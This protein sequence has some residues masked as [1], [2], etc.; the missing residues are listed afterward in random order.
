[1]LID[2][3]VSL[4]QAVTA[5]AAG[6]QRSRVTRY[7]QIWGW[8]DD[9]KKMERNW[10]EGQQDRIPYRNYIYGQHGFKNCEID[11]RLRQKAPARMALSRVTEAMAVFETQDFYRAEFSQL[12]ASD[13]KEVGTFAI[14]AESGETVSPAEVPE[15]VPI[16]RGKRMEKEPGFKR[17]PVENEA[18]MQYV[19]AKCGL[20]ET[21]KEVS[22][23]QAFSLDKDIIC[24]RS[25]LV[26]LLEYVS[27][28]LTSFLMPKG[29][30]KN[31]VDL[32][33]ISKASDGK[34]LVMEHLLDVNRMKCF[35][36][37]GAW[38]RSEVSNHGTYTPA[39]RRLAYGDCKTKTLMITGLPQIAGSSAGEIDSFYR[40]VEFDMGGIS[41]LVKTPAHAQKDGENVELA[42]K[43]WYY[44]NEVKAMTTYAKMLLGKVD[45]FVLALQRSGKIHQASDLQSVPDTGWWQP[46]C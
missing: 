33:K 15:Y 5:F 11:P 3:S 6:L 2:A 9:Y 45:R 28:N 44:Q 46:A 21:A 27:D 39:F 7:G 26:T 19:D 20:Y 10:E 1:M 4:I 24:D 29:Q 41:F 23:K 30:H 38:K 31:P 13:V 22:S 16:K 8:R 25:S 34:G 35:P 42:H 37:R 12:T 17:P 18:Y 14:K 40:F 36:Y 43:N 32:V